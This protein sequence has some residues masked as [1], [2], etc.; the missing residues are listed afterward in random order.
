MRI[1]KPLLL[2][3]VVTAVIALVAPWAAPAY[4]AAPDVSVRPLP[5]PVGP[6][7]TV[8]YV[9][10]S[11]QAYKI[12]DGGTTVPVTTAAGVTITML[13]KSGTGYLARLTP[14]DRGDDTIVR[15]APGATQRTIL[16]G[17]SYYDLVGTSEDGT[18][19]FS[20]TWG[21]DSRSMVLHVTD[22]RTGAAVARHTFKGTTAA[23]GL[24]VSGDRVLVGGEAPARTMVWNRRTGAIRTVA[25]RIAYT[26][27][28]RTD[29]LAT[30]TKDPLQQGACSVVSTLSHPGSALWRSCDEAVAAFSPD[31]ARIATR[32][33]G[34]GDN[35]TYVRR[36]SVHGTLLT[37]YRN[38]NAV[39][40]YAWESAT[41][42]L[43]RSYPNSGTGWLVRCEAATCERTV[44][45]L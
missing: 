2:T 4:A 22:A 25:D 9:A 16:D 42:V 44:R 36:R 41:R 13:K 29:R 24:D 43:L 20:T 6:A 3:A 33:L 23:T 19:L 8:A 37:T 35:F 31:G 7:P 21:R 18:Y 26:G 15:V 12:V 39:Y 34:P 1:S 30:Y 10:G 14:D 32:A 40:L 5:L 17:V 38:T 45:A 11:D 28:F 27:S